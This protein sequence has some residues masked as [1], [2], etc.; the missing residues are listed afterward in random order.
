MLGRVISIRFAPLN[1]A[2]AVSMATS[3]ALTE[4]FGV[5]PVLAAWGALTAVVGLAG[6]AV[7]SIRRV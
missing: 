5:R 1:A 7:Q 4:A 3:G 6:L 2:L